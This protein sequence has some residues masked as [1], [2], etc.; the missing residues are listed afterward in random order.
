MLKTDYL[1]NALA[2]LAGVLINADAQACIFGVSGLH[3]VM[4]CR[5]I[6]SRVAR[7]A[8]MLQA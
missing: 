2:F 8:Q 6:T 7:F 1:V 5:G 4:H 3:A